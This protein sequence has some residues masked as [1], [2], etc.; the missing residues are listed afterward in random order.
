M[1]VVQK[2]A[3]F[4]TRHILVI[5]SPQLK[6][7]NDPIDTTT[8]HGR[9]TFNIFASLAEFERDLIRQRTTAGLTAARAR[10]RLGGRPKGLSNGG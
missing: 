10:G 7:L 9:L 4:S 5:N 1:N 2:P 6:S 3:L 8:P